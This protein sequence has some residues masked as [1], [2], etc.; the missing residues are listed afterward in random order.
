[1]EKK[2]D[3]QDFL[4]LENLNLKIQNLNMQRGILQKDFEVSTEALNKL[5]A[6]MQTLKKELEEL[7]KSNK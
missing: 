1:M 3:G 2:L 6:E 4:R 7:T 5:Q